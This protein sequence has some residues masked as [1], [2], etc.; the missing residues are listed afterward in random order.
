MYVFHLTSITENST[1]L[2]TIVVICQPYAPMLVV[3]V[4]VCV[5]VCFRTINLE[6]TFNVCVRALMYVRMLYQHGTYRRIPRT[7][8][9]TITTRA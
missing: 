1:S 4:C 8:A 9:P 2:Y 3:C 5:C 7:C 6:F